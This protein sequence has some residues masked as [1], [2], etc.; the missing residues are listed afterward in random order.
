MQEGAAEGAPAS[1]QL[2]SE[3][4]QAEVCPSTSGRWADSC[5]AFTIL[6]KPRP[7]FKPGAYDND[8]SFGPMSK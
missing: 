7:N 3:Q 2:W 4:N 1:L 6:I 5:G 8:Y